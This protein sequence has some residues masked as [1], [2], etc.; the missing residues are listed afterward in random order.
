MIHN[1]GTKYGWEVNDEGYRDANGNFCPDGDRGGVCRA[2]SGMAEENLNYVIQMFAKYRN[3]PYG[4]KGK[5]LEIFFNDDPGS[6]PVSG[7]PSGEGPLFEF[8]YRDAREV[9]NTIELYIGVNEEFDLSNSLHEGLVTFELHWSIVDFLS[10]NHDALVDYGFPEN[11]VPQGVDS[12]AFPPKFVL[13]Q[14]VG[15]Q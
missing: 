1:M 11:E 4:G 13:K 10:G 7:N 2:Y 15:S 5:T 3:D 9:G 8:W 14:A 6:Y 12:I